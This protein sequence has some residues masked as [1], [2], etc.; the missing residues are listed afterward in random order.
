MEILLLHF[1]YDDD[2]VLERK[3]ARRRANLHVLR[4]RPGDPVV[5]PASLCARLDGAINY[6]TAATLGHPAKAFPRCRIVVRSGVGFENVDLAEWGRRGVPVCNVPD[7]GVSEVADHAIALM[8]AL[9][10]GTATYHDAL[11]C[12]P[13]GGWRFPAAPLVRRLRGAVFGVVGLGR[14]GLAAALRARGFGMDVAFYDPYLPSGGEIAAGMRR[15]P[16]LD[17]LMAEADVLSIHAPLS[18]ETRFMIGKAALSRA[19]PGMIVINTARG[20]IVD[21]KA[22]HDALKSGRVGGAGIDVLER[23]PADPNHPLIAAWRRREPWLEG[24]LTL[25]PHAAFY[26][27]ASIAD[28]RTKSLETVLAYLEGGAAQNCVNAA[29]LKSRRPR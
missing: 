20:P 14:I 6:S 12:D 22:L 28:L 17:K 21:L 25:S 27:P 13:V 9:A 7:Y 16:S 4:N 29:F 24:R 3:L 2:A 5:P 19:K 15:A 23:E 11:R 8:L 26:S 1:A 18:D 10:R